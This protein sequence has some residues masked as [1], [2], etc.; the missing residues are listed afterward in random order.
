M[1]KHK[2]WEEI[3]RSKPRTD[4]DHDDKVAAI[5]AAMDDAVHL[6]D[7]REARG[8]T[9][10]DVARALDVSRARVSAVERQQ[11][12]YVETLREYVEAIGGRLELV[13]A[14]GEDRITIEPGAREPIKA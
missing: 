7:L 14:F 11:G 10:A 6:A 2:S 1:P 9:Q 8:L 12:L 4:P 13:A 5:R 3:R